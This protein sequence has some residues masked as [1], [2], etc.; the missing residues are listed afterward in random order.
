MRKIRE[1]SQKALGVAVRNHKEGKGSSVGGYVIVA[2]A[3]W[4]GVQEA[5]SLWEFIKLVDLERVAVGITFI[6]AVK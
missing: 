5:E 1:E 3:L 2:L 6:F 4:G